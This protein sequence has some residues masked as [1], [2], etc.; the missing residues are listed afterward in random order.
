MEWKKI[1]L[2][3]VWPVE[4]QNTSRLLT[5]NIDCVTVGYQSRN[6]SRPTMS[7]V[8][9]VCSTDNAPRWCQISRKSTYTTYTDIPELTLLMLCNTVSWYHT[10]RCC[11]LCKHAYDMVTKSYWIIKSFSPRRFHLT[12]YHSN[13]KV[14]CKF[15]RWFKHAYQVEIKYEFQGN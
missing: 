11:E 10:P 9:W 8:Y 14:F 4:N 6:T 2:F 12:V 15:A 3:L 1:Q 5:T 13:D 7:L